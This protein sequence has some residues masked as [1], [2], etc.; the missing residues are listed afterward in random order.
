MK[1][2]SLN[3]FRKESQGGLVN[4]GKRIAE[5]LKKGFGLLVREKKK[6]MI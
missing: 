5:D 1:K 2:F 3:E 4:L 6:K